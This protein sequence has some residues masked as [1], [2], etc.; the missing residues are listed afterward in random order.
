M[1]SPSPCSR[2]DARTEYCLP[3]GRLV[4]SLTE[5]ARQAAAGHHPGR[6]LHRRLCHGQ[7][8]KQPKARADI[9]QT[10]L[11]RGPG[12]ELAGHVLPSYKT[13]AT[14]STSWKTATAS[15][16][17]WPRAGRLDPAGRCQRR[18]PTDPTPPL[19]GSPPGRRPPSLD[20]SRSISGPGS[21][22]RPSHSSHAAAA[23]DAARLSRSGRH[24]SSGPRRFER[25]LCDSL[26]PQRSPAGAAP[27]CSL[28]RLGA[29]GSL[30][31]AAVAVR[32]PAQRAE[33]RAA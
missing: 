22:K 15:G 18:R 2:T 12:G 9:Q 21:A 19:S 6:T 5:L 24:R 17:R 1:S 8:R 33:A 7:R 28:L 25:A 32:L 23:R 11:A 3:L 30:L 4:E 27:A 20:R 13:P 16:P 26:H 14:G 31:A 29:S 10:L